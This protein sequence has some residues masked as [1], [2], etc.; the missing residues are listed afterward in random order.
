MA[1]THP[2]QCPFCENYL[3][4]PVNL[5]FRGLE[6]TGGI[7][8]CGAIYSLDETGHAMGEIFMDALTFLC[9]GDIDRALSLNPE[10]Y[11]CLDFDYDRETNSTGR[12][13]NSGKL[14]K[15]LF[16]KLKQ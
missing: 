5:T 2:L 7:C 1:R 9:R 15:I 13:S 8:K 10:D 4:A 11:E 12:R 14:G 6:V 16:L 3:I